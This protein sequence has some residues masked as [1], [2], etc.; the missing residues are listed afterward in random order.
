[1][2]TSD[3]I[4]D[5]ER[6]ARVEALREARSPK[7]TPPRVV[8]S[9]TLLTGLLKCTCGHR[10]TVVTGKSGRYHY[11]KCSNRQSKGNH[12]CNSRNFPMEKLD[13]LIINQLVDRICTRERL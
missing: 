4:I 8:S 10:I 3:P 9:P 11:Y 7:N 5:R 2:V 12:V 1:M 13:D 6:F